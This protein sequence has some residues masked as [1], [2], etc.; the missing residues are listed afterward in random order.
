MNAKLKTIV[1]IILSQGRTILL[2][3]R[4]SIVWFQNSGTT[5]YFFRKTPINLSSIK[6]LDENK[7]DIAWMY[8]ASSNNS[9][10]EVNEDYSNIKLLKED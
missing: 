7:E 8:M 10:S 2:C 5:W 1:Y 3:D 4:S 6:E 9:S